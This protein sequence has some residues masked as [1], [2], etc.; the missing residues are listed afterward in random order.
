MNDWL[1]ANETVLKYLLDIG[2]ESYSFED[3]VFMFHDTD[4]MREFQGVINA[5]EKA[6]QKMTEN[7]PSF[8]MM[9]Y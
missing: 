4:H 2:A 9:I 3:P 7:Y 8:R 5:R 1:L 6:L